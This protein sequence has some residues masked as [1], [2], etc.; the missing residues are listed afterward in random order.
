MIFYEFSD[1]F[2]QKLIEILK[3]ENPIGDYRV[4]RSLSGFNNSLIK[5]KQNYTFI[6]DDV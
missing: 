2:V 6:I 3:R 5:F 1:E 4:S